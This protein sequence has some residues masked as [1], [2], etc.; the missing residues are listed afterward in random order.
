MKFIP[1]DVY[2]K[3]GSESPKDKSWVLVTG[4][5][6]GIGLAFCKC[7]AKDHGFNIIM[8]GRLG[9]KLV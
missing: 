6:D 8:V 3:Y 7:L 1:N 4:A 9:N 5:T 2:S